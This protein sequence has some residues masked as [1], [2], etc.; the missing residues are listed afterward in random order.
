MN[1]ELRSLL[2]ALLLVLGYIAYAQSRP[3]FVFVPLV[4]KETPYVHFP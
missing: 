1:L 4:P 2:I 3:H